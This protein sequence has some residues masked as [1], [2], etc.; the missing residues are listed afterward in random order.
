LSGDA[1]G[2]DS[3]DAPIGT[4]GANIAFVSSTQHTITEFASDASGADA[5]CA[6]LASGAGMAGT[7]IAY[8]SSSPASAITRLS[9]ARGWVRR[10]GRP[11]ADLSSDLL[12]GAQ[13]YPIALDEN[14]VDLGSV[15]VATGGDTGGGNNCSDYSSTAGNVEIGSSYATTGSWSTDQL[16]PCSQMF[17]LYCFGVDHNAPLQRV[18]ATGRRAFIT[19]NTFAV[20]G[21]LPAADALCASEAAALGGTFKALLATTSASAISR[22]SLAGAPWVRLDGIPLAD[23]ASLVATGGLRAP[24]NVTPSLAYVTS[25]VFTGA[26]QPNAT[27][28]AAADTC[29]N[30][31]ITNSAINGSSS[32]IGGFFFDQGTVNCQARKV[33]CLEL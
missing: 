15:V 22:F 20:G 32:Y 12:G 23:T 29:S 9:N 3:T 7:Y 8:L 16:A 24:L 18:P 19:D 28:A 30:W 2:V 4:S 26:V 11:V 6:A 5:I 31:T 10:D 14:G 33:Y 27:G 17:H 1:S 13:F 21:G 25:I